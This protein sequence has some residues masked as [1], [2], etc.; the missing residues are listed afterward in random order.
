LDQFRKA[1]LDQLKSELKTHQQSQQSNN[2]NSKP[3]PLSGDVLDRFAS[4]EARLSKVEKSTSS[5]SSASSSVLDERAINDQLNE[6][7][8]LFE[9][10][11]DNKLKTVLDQVMATN[12]ELM[13][14]EREDQR[15]LL[16]EQVA[17][18]QAQVVSVLLVP[19]LP[20]HPA[21][22][23]CAALVDRLSKQS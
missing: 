2:S 7:L 1:S 16:M 20:S 14:K 21:L 22:S 6:K 12:K 13:A 4:L 17:K 23:V 5:A 9:A 11:Y 18:Q 10:E 3:S 19:P 8:S 15:A